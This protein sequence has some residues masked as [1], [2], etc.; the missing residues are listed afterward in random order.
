MKKWGFANFSAKKCKKSAFLLI[1]GKK[2]VNYWN[3]QDIVFYVR[4]AHSRAALT[5]PKVL[6]PSSVRL[7]RFILN[8]LTVKVTKVTKLQINV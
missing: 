6:R 7:F 1:F 8:L 4:S 3:E 2:I 5:P